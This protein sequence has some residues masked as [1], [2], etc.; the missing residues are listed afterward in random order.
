MASTGDKEWDYVIVGSGAGGGTLAA[1]LVESG[2]RVFLTEAGRGAGVGRAGRGSRPA[3]S[4][5]ACECFCSRRVAMR[6]SVGR[7]GCPTT[8][9]C[10]ASMRTP[11]RTRPGGG[12]SMCGTMGMK[13]DR[14][15]TG[16]VEGTG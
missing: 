13:R 6:V 15:A 10:Q 3:W 11:V 5:R 7:H 4:N 2:V 14:V 16:N 9:T 8:T 1:R 12:I